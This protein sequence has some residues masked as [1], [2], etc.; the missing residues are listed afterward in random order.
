VRVRVTVL[1]PVL[2]RVW[3]NVL[4]KVASCGVGDSEKVTLCVA[5]S[6]TV[7]V[8]VKVRVWLT[9]GDTVTDQTSVTERVGEMV[10][11]AVFVPV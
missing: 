3:V 8:A 9:V 1:V 10:T 6:T 5:V 11:E 2:V 4:V 7:F